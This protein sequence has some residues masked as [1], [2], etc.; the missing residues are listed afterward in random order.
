MKAV[1]ITEFGGTEHLE[2]RDVPLP[3]APAGG[4]VIVG[5]KYAGLNRADLLQRRGLYPPP[6]GYDPRIPGLEFAG[7]VEQIG[8]GLS[9]LAVGDKVFGI[10]AGEAQAEFVRV[11]SRLVA[12]IQ[13]IEMES[14]AAV[15][16]AYVTAH[17]ALISQ[18]GLQAG[19]TVLIHAVASGVGLAAAQIVKAA[20]ATVIGTSR[21]PDK[22]ERLM[23]EAGSVDHTIETSGGPIFA[24]RVIELTDGRGVSVVL[25][26]V[27]GAYL[28]ENLKSMALKGR[29][30]LVGLT[31]GRTAEFD[32][33]IALTKRLSIKGTVLRSRSGDE[34]AQAME[35]FARDILPGIGSKYVPVVDRVFDV[36]DIAAAH[37]YLA[38]DES[39]GKVILRF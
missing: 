37:E 14:A 6:E 18:A 3:S 12:K 26:L 9:D 34:K 4:E 21:S 19:E 38:S 7:V 25:D 28:P 17:D 23:N 22:L 29:I 1:Y 2:I 5:V 33:G 10:T 20:E 11:A 36:A 15:P 13:Q 16:E 39:F 8:D 30:M 27:G 24:E 32:M 31:A 35:A